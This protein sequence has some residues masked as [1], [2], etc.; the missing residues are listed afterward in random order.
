MSHGFNDWNVMPLH[1]YRIYDTIR[2]LGIPSRIYYH[3]DG[4]GGPPPLSMMNRW[5]TRYLHGVENGVE[6]EPRAWI[7]REDADR[8]NPTA[9]PDYP[10]PDAKQVQ[11]YLEGGAP[12]HGKLTLQANPTP[13]T[14]TLIDNF[15]FSGSA[16]AQAEYTDHR[17]IYLSPVLKDSIHISGI[18]RIN[19]RIASSKPFANLSVWLVSLP[20]NEGRR[21]KI[22]DNII[23]RGWADIQ[24]HHSLTESKPLVP[25]RFYELEFELQPDDQV[26]PAGQQIGLMIFSSDKDFT[27]WPDPGTKLTVDLEY[28][29]V[30]IP[31]VGGKKKIISAFSPD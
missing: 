11:L 27:L 20:W 21:T 14:E 24:N 4:H 15:S 9:Y 12:G 6:N 1:S 29:A 23:T 17:L 30:S 25:G 28:T 8:E 2:S 31:V 10:N 18:P 19:I 5:F 26:I 22:T 16:L 13:G 7:V 3:Q